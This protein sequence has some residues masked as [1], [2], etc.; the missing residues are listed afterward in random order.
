MKKVLSMLVLSVFVY[1]IVTIFSGVAFALLIVE[2]DP[3]A[4]DSWHQRLRVFDVDRF[5]GIEM[6]LSGGVFKKPNYLNDSSWNTSSYNS[7]YLSLSGSAIENLLF[8]V[9]FEGNDF[10]PLSIS[11]KYGLGGKIKEKWNLF[12]S[13]INNGNHWICSR[14]VPDEGIMWLLGPAFI[15]LGLLGRKG[16]NMV[17]KHE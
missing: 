13:G 11:L 16:K 7:N 6:R 8:E 14:S 9:I 3:Y 15:A 10:Q 2:G 1:S 12:Y 5:D 17:S 4:G